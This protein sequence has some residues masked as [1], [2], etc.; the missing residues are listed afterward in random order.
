VL[1]NPFATVE[2][3]LT[4]DE[5]RLEAEDVAAKLAFAD[6]SWARLGSQ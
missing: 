4:R 2:M 6:A 5:E 3:A 1:L